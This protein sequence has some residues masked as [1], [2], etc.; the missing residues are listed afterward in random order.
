MKPKREKQASLEGIPHPEP[1]PILRMP[2]NLEG[3]ESESRGPSPP[4]RRKTRL[5][6]RNRPGSGGD[7]CRAGRGRTP[8]T[9]WDSFPYSGQEGGVAGEGGKGQGA[10]GEAAPG[11]PAASGGAAAQS[12]A[13]PGSP[14]G[15]AA[16]EA[17]EKQGALVPLSDQARVALCACVCTLLH[18]DSVGM[19]IWVHVCSCVLWGLQTVWFCMCLGGHL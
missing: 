19:H 4:G 3:A 15:A 8:H 5:G 14:G 9:P 16:A 13:T 6:G 2:F 1:E 10:A 11:A 17:G 18:A 7:S 12:R